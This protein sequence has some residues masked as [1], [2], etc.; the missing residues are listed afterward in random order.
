M[1]LPE[2]VEE[3]DLKFSDEAEPKTAPQRRFGRRTLTQRPDHIVGRDRH[4]GRLQ[5]DQ[6]VVDDAPAIGLNPDRDR[7]RTEAVVVK[8][9][10]KKWDQP[11]EIIVATVKAALTQ[12]DEQDQQGEHGDDL[13]NCCPCNTGVHL[14]GFQLPQFS[15][16]VYSQLGAIDP[17]G[18]D[19]VC[20]NCAYLHRCD[21]TF[22]KQTKAMPD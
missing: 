17:N 9:H 6:H 13:S 7:G 15:A 2:D 3:S 20:R 11:A 10:R 16:N 19:R 18:V 8:L 22:N 1:A 21:H 5:V 12:L 14:L 4:H